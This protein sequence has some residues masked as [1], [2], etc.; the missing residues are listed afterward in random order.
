MEYHH[1]LIMKSEDKNK[2]LSSCQFFMD[3]LLEIIGS[4]GVSAVLKIVTGKED[5]SKDCINFS[6]LHS[7]SNALDALYGPRGGRGIALRSGR[8]SLKYFLR[9]FGEDLLLNDIDF[10]M[11]PTRKRFKDGLSRLMKAY[12]E[13]FK[14]DVNLLDD[15][16]TWIWQSLN[17]TECQERQSQ[18]TACQFTEGLLQEFLSWCGGNKNYPITEISCCARGDEI[19]QYRID[20]RPIE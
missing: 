10:K 6:D 7:I 19:C 4:A 8:A 20:P 18:G 11:K 12:Q 1:R 17:C 13:K 5:V 16:T 3:G 15:G 14:I 9:A 2:P